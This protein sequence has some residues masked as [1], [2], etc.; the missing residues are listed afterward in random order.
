MLARL[1]R[2]KVDHD[3][4][5]ETFDGHPSISIRDCEGDPP[6]KYVFIMTVPALV[7]RKDGGLDTAYEHLVEVILPADYPRRAPFFR[8]LSPVYHP[9][10]D[11]HKVCTG[12]HWSA[13]SSLAGMV[14]QVAEMLCFQ[15]YNTKSPLNGAAAVWAMSNL[16]R[17][18]LSSVDLGA[19]T[20]PDSDAAR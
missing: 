13:G 10:I 19:T 8:M 11:P 2:M 6:E 16:D 20:T 14:I 9:N 1:R 17:L 15:S 3:Q 12:D 5:L 7:P 4:V 18:P